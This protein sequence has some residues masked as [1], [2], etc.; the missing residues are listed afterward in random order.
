MTSIPTGPAAPPAVPARTPRPRRRRLDPARTN[1]WLDI[2]L[3]A[4]MLLALA[5]ILTGIAL[6]EWIAIALWI[7]VGVHLLLH[8][9][10]AV[11]VLRRFAGHLPSAA[12]LNLVLAILF[13][14]ALALVMVS[15]LLIS[16]E[17]L[18]TLGIR[19]FAG[20][21][22]ERI[23]RIS[24][25]WL[26]VL[27]ALHVALHWRWIIATA[28]HWLWDPIARRVRPRPTAAVRVVADGE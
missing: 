2:L 6:H 15:G 16:R 13:F 24:A 17:A 1:L 26:V 3:T 20:R 9:D 25:D 27:T 28:K 5:P 12:R 18:P 7:A 11:N 23:H 8:W 22:W 14:V 19:L 10:W 4:A 21:D